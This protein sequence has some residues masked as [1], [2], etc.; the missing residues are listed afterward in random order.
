MASD[1]GHA[2]TTEHDGVGHVVPLRLLI[3]VLAVLLVLTF[4]TVA[5]TWVPLGPFN[6]A[7][8][9]LIATVKGSLVLVMLFVFFALIDSQQYQPDLIPGFAPE[10]AP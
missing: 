8:A 6:L 5:V 7:V 10:L 4:V 3:G 1:T 9:L 2:T